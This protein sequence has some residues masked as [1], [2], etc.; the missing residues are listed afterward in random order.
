MSVDDIKG[1]A[2]SYPDSIDSLIVVRSGDTE[3]TA[4]ACGTIYDITDEGELEWVQ[5]ESIMGESNR[6]DWTG[7]TR[8]SLNIS[9]GCYY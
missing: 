5:S 1:I 8:R 2:R 9:G 4:T 3:D 7:I 6:D